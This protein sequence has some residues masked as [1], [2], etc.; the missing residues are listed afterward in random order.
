M[1]LIK[2]TKR[3]S[4][5]VNS[6]SKIMFVGDERRADS[7]HAITQTNAMVPIIGIIINCGFL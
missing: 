5:N 1:L 4:K 6:P 2:P 7:E 3:D